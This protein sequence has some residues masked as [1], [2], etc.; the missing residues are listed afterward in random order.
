MTDDMQEWRTHRQP[1][2]LTDSL[3]RVMITHTLYDIWALRYLHREFV[4]LGLV[5]EHVAPLANRAPE[6]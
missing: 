3:L 4:R 6:S 1:A 2:W 5:G